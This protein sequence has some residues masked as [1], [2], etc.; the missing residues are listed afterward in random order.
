MAPALALLGARLSCSLHGCWSLLWAVLPS[1]SPVLSLRCAQPW[2]CP[3]W[4]SPALCRWARTWDKV[5]PLWSC[6]R[7]LPAPFLGFTS[8]RALPSGTQKGKLGAFG[9]G[10]G[11]GGTKQSPSEP[12][13]RAGQLGTESRPSLPPPPPPVHPAGSVSPSGLQEPCLGCFGAG[14]PAAP[15][16]HV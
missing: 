3:P 8:Q 13:A 11:R 1:W 7:Q 15:H 14:L 4:G 12:P 16:V 10:R 9:L 2:G 6:S 5:G